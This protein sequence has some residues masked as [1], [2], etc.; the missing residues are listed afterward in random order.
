MSTLAAR[1]NWNRHW[2]DYAGAAERNPAQRFRRR[3]ILSAL[4][5]TPD[6]RVLDIGSGQGDLAADIASACPRVEVLGLELSASGVEVASRK[7]P[8]ATFLRRDLL[9]PHRP[10][11]KWRGWATHAVCSE[12]LEHLDEPWSLLAHA[13]AWM[14]PG[15]KFVV[16]VPGG[17]M[18]A[19]DKHIGHRRH[20]R[21]DEL[22][23]V[24]EESGFHVTRAAGAGFPFFNLYRCVVIARGSGLIR[25]VSGRPC[26]SARLA[27]NTFDVLFQLNRFNHGWQN[28]AVATLR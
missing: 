14:A 18:S 26:W 19:F 23:Q 5:L 13:K 9:Q 22:R 24:L 27:M 6:A 16:T 11:V 25:D 28:V 21:P 20:Y 17:P 10:P 15:C 8:G 1:D 7:V 3:L 12:V 4:S 2:D